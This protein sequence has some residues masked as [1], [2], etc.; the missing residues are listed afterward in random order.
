M[1]GTHQPGST[2]LRAPQWWRSRAAAALVVLVGYALLFY[3]V[4]HTRAPRSS[5][6][7]APML[8]PVISKVGV[9]RGEALAAR[10]PAVAAEDQSMPPAQHWIF[11]PID[12]W[13]SAPGWTASP[14]EFTPVTDAQPDPPEK[15]PAVDKGGR[16]VRRSILRMARW[17]RPSYPA[18]WASAGV[19]GS[20]V[21]DL[22]ISPDGQP[23]EI[24]VTQGSGFQELDQ[25]AAHAASNWRFAPPRWN[26]RPVEVW[27]RIDVRFVARANNAG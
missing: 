5:S 19:Q 24:K 8:S 3:L 1:H 12:L 6:E 25:S 16:P 17:L 4:A 10:P 2:N 23:I 9:R 26:S 7:G 27:G 11:P 15:P 13:P 18:D 14:S 21:L 20:V 22:L